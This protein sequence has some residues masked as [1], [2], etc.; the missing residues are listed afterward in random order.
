MKACFFDYFLD[1]DDL[2][3]RLDELLLPARVRG[4]VIDHLPE[5]QIA[6]HGDYDAMIVHP[7]KDPVK[8]PGIVVCAD[9][10]RVVRE[11]DKP[12]LIACGLGCSSALREAFGERPNLEYGVLHPD[13]IIEFLEK[14]SK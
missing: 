8:A 4:H 7:Y 6:L 2:L 12:V 11:A 14:Y 13:T 9:T 5:S 3:Y 10:L 1:A